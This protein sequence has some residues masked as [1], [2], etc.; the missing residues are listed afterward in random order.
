MAKNLENDL[1]KALDGIEQRAHNS[2]ELTDDQKQTIIVRA[3][4][5]VAER[6]ENQRDEQRALNEK[7]FFERA[8]RQAEKEF[9]IGGAH[10]DIVLDLAPNQPYIML[11]G[12]TYFHGVPYEV[13]EAQARTMMDISARGWE[14]DNEIHGEKRRADRGRRPRNAQIGPGKPNIPGLYDN[15]ANVNTSAMPSV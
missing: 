8:V 9:Q 6:L 2:T 14:H 10:V 7:R 5:H 4:E 15:R 13:S 12:T 1:R 3:R 11:D